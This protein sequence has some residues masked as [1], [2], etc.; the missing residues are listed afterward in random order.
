[1]NLRQVDDTVVDPLRRDTE[2]LLARRL[3]CKMPSRSFSIIRTPAS[4]VQSLRSEPWAHE[5]SSSVTPTAIS[6]YS[7]D[8]AS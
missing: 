3:L 1:L 7:P 5:R 6:C 2:Q 8:E 4:T